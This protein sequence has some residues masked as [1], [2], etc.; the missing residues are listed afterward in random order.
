M[1]HRH[2]RSFLKGTILVYHQVRLM[3]PSQQYTERALQFN[4]AAFFW[5]LHQ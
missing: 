2:D 5:P 3:Q 4:P 1:K